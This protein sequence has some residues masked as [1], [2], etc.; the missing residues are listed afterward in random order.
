MNDEKKVMKSENRKN[1]SEK[2]LSLFTDKTVNIKIDL[3]K[4]EYLY[5]TKGRPFTIKI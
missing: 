4:K 1:L 5:L 2:Q 3:E